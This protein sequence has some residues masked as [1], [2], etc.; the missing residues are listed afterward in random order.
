[1]E[2]TD[3]MRINRFELRRLAKS[4]A[5]AGPWLMT[6]ATAG[7]EAQ[8]FPFA[9]GPEHPLLRPLPADSPFAKFDISKLSNAKPVDVP[10]PLPWDGGSMST[11]VVRDVTRGVTAFGG[12][13]EG[14]SGPQPFGEPALGA[15]GLSADTELN[16]ALGTSGREGTYS[17]IGGDDRVLVG[18]TEVF[19]WRVQCKLVF[20]FRDGSTYVGSGTLVNRKYLL[21]AGHCVYDPSRG[22]ATRMEVVPGLNGTYMP[23]GAAFA[24]AFRTYTGWTRYASADHDFALV[25]LDRNIGSSTGWFGYGY[26]NSFIGQPGHIAGYPNDRER[27][28]RLFY[29]ALPI[30]FE[31]PYRLWYQTDTGPGQ[32]GSSVYRVINGNRYAVGVHTKGATTK[33]GV[34][35][36]SGTR[37]D[38]TK[39]GSIYRWIAAGN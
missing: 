19:P 30:R 6:L 33:N 39:C 20:R 16:Y 4:L 24:T 31:S 34:A 14:F 9:P 22:W 38:A 11:E 15:D 13:A 10:Q 2:D 18:P 28:L 36:N 35:C 37:L 5:L 25:T 8:D 12:T 23:Y 3:Q 27:G 29:H 7:A 1:M 26:A 21:T 17:V 32:S